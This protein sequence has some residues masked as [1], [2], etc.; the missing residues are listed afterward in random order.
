MKTRRFQLCEADQTSPNLLGTWN[1][2][3]FRRWL[4]GN[5]F[6]LR[7]VRAALFAGAN[8]RHRPQWTCGSRTDQSTPVMAVA[9]YYKSG[10]GKAHTPRGC[11]PSAAGD[12]A[13]PDRL[14]TAN[15]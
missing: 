14:Q 12:A 8:R 5:G 6:L 10:L 3:T 9:E 7:F 15:A 2:G 1:G 13:R 4:T 11:N